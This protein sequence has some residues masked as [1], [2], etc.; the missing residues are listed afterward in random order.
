MKRK[1]IIAALILGTV[2]IAQAQGKGKDSGSKGGKSEQKE[3]GKPDK[4]PSAISKGIEKNE[5]N[6]GLLQ[7]GNGNLGQGGKDKHKGNGNSDKSDHGKPNGKEHGNGHGNDLNKDHGNGNAY[8]NHKGNLSGRE[9]GQAR[10]AAARSKHQNYQLVTIGDGRRIIEIT[11]KRNIEL[12]T[13]TKRKL[14]DAR[15][16]L[17]EMKIAG[18]LTLG[19]FEEKIQT[20]QVMEE[21]R[22]SIELRVNI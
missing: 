19:A 14:S 17:N 13:I 6:G 4:G 22:A 3:N 18:T 1:I 11:L 8:G 9:F 12:L 2:V 20:I 21:R 15:L 16:R 5:G 10:A 7:K